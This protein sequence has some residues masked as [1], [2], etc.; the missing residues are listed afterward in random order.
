MLVGD[1]LRDSMAAMAAASS[2]GT[3]ES[4]DFSTGMEMTSIV[5]LGGEV[6]P[7]SVG[8]PVGDIS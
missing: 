1:V 7:L 4:P 2:S 3:R 5:F 6:A 8:E